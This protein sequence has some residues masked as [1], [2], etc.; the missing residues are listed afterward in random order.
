MTYVRTLALS[1]LLALSAA[2]RADVMINEIMYHPSSENPADE[3][4]ELY[5]SGVLPVTL[6]GWKFTSGVTFT[7]PAASIA[8]G[9]YLVVAA[10]HGQILER[11]RDL[12]RRQ[13]RVHPLRKP[14]Q[15][16]FLQF[17]EPPEKLAI[18]DLSRSTHRESLNEVLAAVAGHPEWENCRRCP[19]QTADRICPISENRTRMLDQRDG[20]RFARRL[21]DVV[22]VARLNGWHL[23]IRDLLALAS[24]MILGHPNAKE[25]LMACADIAKI[26]ERGTLESANLYGNVFGSN[27]TVR[28]AMNRPVFRALASFGIGAETTSA[29][30]GLLVYGADDPKLMDAFNLFLGA[31]SIYGATSGYLA[32]LQQYL[33]GDEAARVDDGSDEFLSRLQGQRRRLFFTLPDAEPDYGFWLMTA[34]RFAGDYLTVVTALSDNKP[35]SETVRARLVR[36]LNRVMTGLLIENNDKLFVASSGGFTQSRISVL[37]DT[38]APA[39][40]SGGVGMRIKLDQVSGKVA[41]D[42]ALAPGD[43]DAASFALSPVRFEFYTLDCSSTR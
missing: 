33:E 26:Q 41:L 13:N 24:N 18:F 29:A 35:I 20:G 28:R 16:A 22:E 25:G 23:P 9:G 17:S 1:F 36:G 8:A 43:A 32:S 27:L 5:N 11:L 40:R 38:E 4:I 3:Y 39:R 34:F 2:V 6:T 14:I 19:L 42:V 15:D 37:C 10:N 12:G 21:G 31:D 7:F 30:D